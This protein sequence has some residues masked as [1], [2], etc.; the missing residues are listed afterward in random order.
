MPRDTNCAFFNIIQGV[1]GVEPMFKRKFHFGEFDKVRQKS[2]HQM[3][4]AKGGSGGQ[5]LFEAAEMVS[6]GIPKGL[7]FTNIE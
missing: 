5:W 2:C 3:F 1:G 4:K 6:R 7:P